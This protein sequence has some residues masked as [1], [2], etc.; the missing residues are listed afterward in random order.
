MKKRFL[1]VNPEGVLVEVFGLT[2]F[3]NKNRLNTGAMSEV[4]SGKRMSY[5]GWK[6]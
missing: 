4:W 1:F 2:D 6:K 3:C 5:K